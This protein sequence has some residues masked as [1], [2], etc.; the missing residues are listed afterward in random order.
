MKKKVGTKNKTCLEQKSLIFLSGQSKEI[1]SFKETSTEFHLLTNGLQQ[2]GNTLI[3]I[4]LNLHIYSYKY[5]NLSLI[6]DPI[7][8]IC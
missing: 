7:I 1:S 4:Y 2:E 3:A 6:N 8:T 5:K